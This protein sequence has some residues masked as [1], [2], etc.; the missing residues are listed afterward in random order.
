MAKSKKIAEK[1]HI[2]VDRMT[3]GSSL[4]VENRVIA[5]NI[6]PSSICF[7]FKSGIIAGKFD[8][9]NGDLDKSMTSPVH[10][11]VYSEKTGEVYTYKKDSLILSSVYDSPVCREKGKLMRFRIVNNEPLWETLYKIKSDQRVY[12]FKDDRIYIE[13]KISNGRF[14]FPICIDKSLKTRSIGVEEQ[15]RYMWKYI[16]H[17]LTEAKTYDVILQECFVPDNNAIESLE[18]V[19][20]SIEEGRFKARIKKPNDSIDRP[21][22]F[23][24]MTTSDLDRMIEELDKRIAACEEE[25]R[26]NRINMNIEEKMS[27]SSSSKNSGDNKNAN[28]TIENSNDSD[29]SDAAKK[30]IPLIDDIVKN[31][32]YYEFCSPDKIEEFKDFIYIIKYGLKCSLEEDIT[33][34]LI[35]MIYACMKIFPAG[36]NIIFPCMEFNDLLVRLLTDKND[37]ERTSIKKEFCKSINNVEKIDVTFLEKYYYE[38]NYEDEEK[39]I[40][41]N[42]ERYIQSRTGLMIDNSVGN[43]IGW[44]QYIVSADTTYLHSIEAVPF[45]DLIDQEEIHPTER[46]GSTSFDEN[47]NFKYAEIF[48]DLNDRLFHLVNYDGIPEDRLIEAMNTFEGREVEFVIDNDYL[49]KLQD[50]FLE[51]GSECLCIDIDEDVPDKYMPKYLGIRY[52]G[53]AVLDGKHLHIY[54]KRVGEDIRNE[55]ESEKNCNKNKGEVFDI[56]LDVNEE[57]RIISERFDM[58]VISKI[59]Q[60]FGISKW[61][62]QKKESD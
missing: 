25:E 26:R 14:E 39:I 33:N 48:Y 2:V 61:K 55:Q 12:R 9:P 24:N 11:F 32:D 21:F 49:V 43:R 59:I 51:E 62:W 60:I 23:D 41:F 1:T 54:K 46:R 44:L 38:T 27:S 53:I 8:V 35:R 56:N 40:G 37:A 34:L 28:D 45:G 15:R 22:S 36:S 3:G 19:V 42:S 20:K 31:G 5:K 50:D 29:E 16:Y 10:F 4:M 7:F 6:I 13:N 47:I 52:I 18:S 30:K 58:N 57:Y 17:G